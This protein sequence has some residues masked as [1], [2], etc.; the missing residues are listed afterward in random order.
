MRDQVRKTRAFAVARN[1]GWSQE[2]PRFIPQ[3]VGNS[4]FVRAI[5]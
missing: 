4:F 5:S 1:S 3:G 2:R